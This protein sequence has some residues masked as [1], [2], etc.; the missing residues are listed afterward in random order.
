MTYKRIA[1]LSQHENGIYEI[2]IREENGLIESAAT[3]LTAFEAHKWAF[4]HKA[5]DIILK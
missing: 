2:S 4:E 3:C 1:E 5:D